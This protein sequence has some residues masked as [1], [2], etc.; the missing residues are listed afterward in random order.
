MKS[1]RIRYPTI[2]VSSCERAT[3]AAGSTGPPQ[4][5]LIRVPSRR[6][7]WYE[8][9]PDRNDAAPYGNNRTSAD[10]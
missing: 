2:L 7:L 10:Y 8:A 6:A 1:M 9:C 5:G 4:A 3:N